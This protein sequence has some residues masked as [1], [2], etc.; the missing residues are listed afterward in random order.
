MR[1]EVGERG[2]PYLNIAQIWPM[3]SA[4]G[5]GMR[6]AVWVQG[7]PFRC[8]GCISPE[9]IPEKSGMQIHPE[10]LA[11]R[12]LEPTGV[13]GLTFSG[14]EPMVQAAGLAVLVR[15][16]RQIRDIDVISFTGFIYE[17][18]KIISAGSGIRRFLD[19]IDVLIDGPYVK[20]LND[21]LGMRGSS[22]QRI[23]YLSERLKEYTLDNSPRHVEIHVQ[24]NYAMMIGV[25]PTGLPEI[26]Q[27][28]LVKE[29]L[30]SDRKG[31]EQ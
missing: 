11:E 1:Q 26:L 6:A 13:T 3:T 12:L 28:K 9:W 27:L 10:E 14:G 2:I 22:N 19:Q 30:D 21:N 16:A 15:H 24:D 20:S 29:T 8:D 17:N 4:L 18:L 31:D 7:C 25:P 5:P 23:I